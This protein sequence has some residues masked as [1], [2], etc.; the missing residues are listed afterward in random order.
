MHPNRSQSTSTSRSRDE[1]AIQVLSQ[2]KTTVSCIRGSD[3]PLDTDVCDCNGQDCQS[4]LW[5][6]ATNSTT[7]ASC[8]LLPKFAGDETASFVTASWDPRTQGSPGAIFRQAMARCDYMANSRSPRARARAPR[9]RARARTMARCDYIA[10]TRSPRARAM[11]R[12]RCRARVRCRYM[13]GSRSPR[14]A[15]QRHRC[16]HRARAMAKATARRRRMV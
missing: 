10:R 2:S 14:A 5:C 15:Y 1:S 7:N 6:Y 4:A 9:C 3:A 16:N 8:N 12:A 11:A 13:A